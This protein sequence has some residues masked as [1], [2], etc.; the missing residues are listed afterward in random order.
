MPETF[1]ASDGTKGWL[2]VPTEEDLKN[3]KIKQ[4]EANKNMENQI[5]KRL[6]EVKSS[7]LP[8]RDLITDLRGLFEGKG[9][10]KD[11]TVPNQDEVAG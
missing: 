2:H 9:S 10:D 4:E 1:E 11:E 5:R 7:Q 8:T 3:E 6:E